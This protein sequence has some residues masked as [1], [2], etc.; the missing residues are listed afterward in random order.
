MVEGEVVSL[1][2]YRKKLEKKKDYLELEDL[3]NQVNEIMDAIG[4][5]EPE[6]YYPIMES[7]VDALAASGIQIG[8]SE[9]ALFNAYYTLI[10]E[11]RE[12]LAD[13]VMEILKMK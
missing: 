12:D 9:S 1:S 7:D 11:G 2:D 5:I 8:P 13:L 3:W 10:H 4:E 6:P